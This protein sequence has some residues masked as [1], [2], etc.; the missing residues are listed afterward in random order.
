MK[1]KVV[2]A[3]DEAPARRELKYL[4]GQTG[5]VDVVGEASSGSAALRVILESQPQLVFLDV[6]MPAMTGLELSNLLGRLPE[7]PLII[8]STAFE[9]YALAAFDAEA[10]DYILKP[11]TFERINKAVMRAM[12]FIGSTEVSARD[13]RQSNVTDQRPE[14]A[15]MHKKIPLYKGEKIIPTSPQDIIFARIEE[16]E[17]SVRTIDGGYRTKFS[18][19]EL[20]TRLQPD[21]FVRVHRSALV[22][23]DHVKEVI[24]W[25]N[26]SYKLVMNDRDR[27]EIL[28]SRYNVKELKQYLNI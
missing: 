27:T 8:F 25:Y 18:L 4:L 15:D 19:N 13:G 21:G 24:P 10:F 16:G 7:K 14:P 26:G 1:M 6:Q 2:I 9:K 3:D 5:C 17:I 20:E 28:V 22:N 12:K 23:S 11:Y